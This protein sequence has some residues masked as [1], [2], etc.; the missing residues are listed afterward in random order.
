M[1][2]LVG[3]LRKDHANV[4]RLLV[5]LKEEVGDLDDEKEG[6][7]ELVRDVMVYMRHYPDVSHHPQED[8]L[9][10]KVAEL[11]PKAQPMVVALKAQH[12]ELAQLGA[13]FLGTLNGVLSGTITDRQVLAVTA[14]EY[15]QIL[16]DHMK[17]EEA[18]IFS[19]AERVL[20]ESDWI[21]LSGEENAEDPV[22]GPMV[23]DAYGSLLKY[24]Q[25]QSIR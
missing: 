16:S 13:Q 9:F 10:D 24:I 20:K 5:I 1:R 22:F 11:R 25:E 7:L 3:Q 23:H 19:L 12:V 21:D 8:R 17:N 15:V 2:D 6:D 4:R 18:E 14:R